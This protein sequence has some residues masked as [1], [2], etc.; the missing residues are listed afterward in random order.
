MGKYREL[1]LANWR[2]G[3]LRNL[4]IASYTPDHMPVP[5]YE[6][7][8]LIHTSVE[9]V[10]ALFG[11]TYSVT[12]N[13]CGWEQDERFTNLINSFDD[14]FFQNYFLATFIV[15]A[16]TT[17]CGFEVAGICI[18]MSDDYP[19]STTGF[20]IKLNHIA[21]GGGDALTDWFGIIPL[22]RLTPYFSV[23]INVNN[24]GW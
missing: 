14:K 19:H 13:P 20:T 5:P 22:P 2:I 10:Q 23:Q 7:L 24:R 16:S 15:T 18:T 11:E 17:G 8:V 1:F 21:I 12:P 9:Q 3:E 6:R 4:P